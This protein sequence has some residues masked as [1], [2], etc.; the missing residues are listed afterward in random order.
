MR[1]SSSLEPVD[2]DGQRH[3]ELVGRPTK[4]H[5]NS[6][7]HD[8]VKTVTKRDVPVYDE[9]NEEQLA[10]RLV[11]NDTIDDKGDGPGLKRPR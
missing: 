6:L 4:R 5:L 11:P 8:G 10:T 1:Q 2:D 9:V 7:R 3:L